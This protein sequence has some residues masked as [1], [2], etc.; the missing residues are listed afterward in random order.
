MSNSQC[1]LRDHLVRTV[2]SMDIDSFTHSGDVQNENTDNDAPSSTMN[3]QLS[4]HL[5]SNV[6]T[7]PKISEVTKGAIV[8]V[9]SEETMQ[10]TKYTVTRKRLMK[11]KL[12]VSVISDEDEKKTY[13]DFVQQKWRLVEI[14][15]PHPS[16]P[17]V[18]LHEC[19]CFED[20][21]NEAVET[22]NSSAI[23]ETSA[24]TTHPISA[25]DFA[26]LCNG[27]WLTD[28]VLD[29]F[30]KNLLRIAKSNDDH[31]TF[32]VSPLLME[33]SRNG[34]AAQTLQ[35]ACGG[36][37]LHDVDV[38]LWPFVHEHHW[39][40]TIGIVGTMEIIFVDP[41]TPYNC[42]KSRCFRAPVRNMITQAYNQMWEPYFQTFNISNDDTWV[43]KETSDDMTLFNI[44]TQPR[45][46]GTDCGVCVCM[47]IWTLITGA[48]VDE[49]L[50]PN[51][52]SARSMFFSEFRRTI[53]DII[54]H[55]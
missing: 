13:K 51:N 36:L 9:F 27:R 34:N 2:E 30:S 4:D 42:S 43:V 7:V 49:D 46:N 33:L 19:D 39:C 48:S 54:L 53:G 26:S 5:S 38:I 50:V 15:E 37:Q 14:S 28:A 16:M 3:E 11:S 23:S 29:C 32:Y 35:Q 18:Y 21:L 41:Y 55:Q 8:S 22:V 45:D 6:L 17:D 25:A 12:Q 47:Y 40:L 31:R 1:S 44:P 52:I 24:S 20:A 10:W